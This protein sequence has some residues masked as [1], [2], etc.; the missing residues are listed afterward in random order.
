MFR[1]RWE[2]NGLPVISGNEK[3][4]SALLALVIDLLDSL[5]GL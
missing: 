5:V 2:N 1:D 3:N 4:V